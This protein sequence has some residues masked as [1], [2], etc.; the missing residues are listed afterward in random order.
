MEKMKFLALIILTGICSSSTSQNEFSKWYFGGGAGLDFST[1][2]PT[3]LTNGFISTTEGVATIC[4]TGGNLLFYTDGIS[5][6]NSQ[7]LMMSN[8]GG[9]NGQNSSTQAV[10]IVKQPGNTNLYYVFT[11]AQVGSING[12]CYSVVDMNLAAGLGSV[13]VKNASLYSPTCE[14]QVAVRH[15]NGRDVW[16]V[17]HEYNSNK[18]RSY[19]L[20]SSGVN[21]TPVISTIGETPGGS[22]GNSAT[23]GHLKI[24]P[25]GKKL[26]SATFTSSIPNTLGFGGFHLFDFDAAN[27][28]VSNSLTLLS[29]QNITSGAGAYGVEFSPDGKKLYG[30]TSPQ[31]GTTTALYQWDICSTNTSV[32]IA[33]QY[34]LS[35]GSSG[36]GSVQWAADGKLYVATSVVQSISIINNPNASGVAMNFS[37]NAIS[38][39]PKYCF[40]GLPNYI[41]TYT[42]PV[43]SLFSNTIACQ[44][45]NFAVPPQPTFTSGCSNVPYAYN[46]YLWDFGEPS[47]GV[48]NTSTLSNPVHTYSTTGT[49]TASLIMYSNCTN[50]TVKKVVNVTTLGPPV[51]VAGVFSTCK[52]DQRTYTVS[53][54]TTYQWSTG[55]TASTVVLSPPATSVYTVTGYSGSCKT[56]QI[57]TVAVNG[58]VGIGAFDKDARVSIFPNPFGDLISIEAS[59]DG[60]LTISDLN[61]TLVLEGKF[62]A[63]HNDINTENLAQGVYLVY[64]KSAWGQTQSRIVKVK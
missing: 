15:C 25:D 14:K 44:S 31:A 35:T 18:F 8:G 30:T 20:T 12:A 51:N 45:V 56:S 50:D 60:Y 61:G 42:R 19:L 21:P 53:G 27:G 37:L 4:D 26:A 28:I 16:I 5:V 2:P 39:A 32:I 11:T 34:S 13:T 41:N 63:G 1:S 40:L 38:L 46:N 59:T 49:Y 22:G 54:G 7:H 64:A 52:G 48:A 62:V 58:C 36:L 9:L 17:S 47:S 24:S 33:S 57:F 10:L 43:P 29:G 6:A 3:S 55:S 23:M